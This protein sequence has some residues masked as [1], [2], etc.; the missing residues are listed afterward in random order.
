M[1]IKNL[2]HD[3]KKNDIQVMQICD[4]FDMPKVKEAI[5]EDNIYYYSDSDI[6]KIIIRSDPG[7]LLFKNGVIIKKWHYN[8]I[9]TIDEVKE[10]LK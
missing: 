3:A 5:G 9:P 2:F 8:N 10:L 7:I 1:N 6:G 4:Y